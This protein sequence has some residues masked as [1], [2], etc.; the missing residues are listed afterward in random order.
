MIACS[1]VK[2]N[3]V[4]GETDDSFISNPIDFQTGMADPGGKI[5]GTENVGTAIPK[6][7]G[8]DPERFLPGVE[9]LNSL[10]RFQG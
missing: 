10:L 2:G 6:L 3:A 5:L 9:P 1:G 8:L 7:G 4:S